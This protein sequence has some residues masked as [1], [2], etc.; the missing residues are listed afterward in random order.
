MPSDPF[1]TYRRVSWALRSYH[2]LRAG[3]RPPHNPFLPPPPPPRYRAELD[4]PELEIV[5]I[6]CDLELGLERLATCRPDYH[7]LL[8]AVYLGGGR[9]WQRLSVS[10][11]VAILAA[12]N[13]VSARTLWRALGH[14]KLALVAVLSGEDP[15]TYGV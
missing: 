2:E 15:S 6:V 12:E 1:W 8:Y 10:N 4:P 14:A 13:N 3:A 9:N 7:R 11:R 5:R